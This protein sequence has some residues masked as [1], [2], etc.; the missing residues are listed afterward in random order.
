MIS[1]SLSWKKNWRVHICKEGMVT[2]K[3][4]MHLKE[5]IIFGRSSKEWPKKRNGEES[6]SIISNYGHKLAL[7]RKRK[8]KKEKFLSKKIK[9]ILWPFSSDKFYV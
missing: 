5:A 6:L 3:M 8:E 4:Q 1:I 7:T 9:F 2:I